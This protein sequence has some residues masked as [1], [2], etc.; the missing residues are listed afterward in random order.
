MIKQNLTLIFIIIISITIIACSQ[1][2]RPLEAVIKKITYVYLRTIL[3]LMP[4]LTTLF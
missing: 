3:K 4:V 2:P 1:G